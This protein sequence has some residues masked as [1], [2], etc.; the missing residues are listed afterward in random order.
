MDNYGESTDKYVPTDKAKGPGHGMVDNDLFFEYEQ[1]GRVI[2]AYQD[3]QGYTYTLHRDG[4]EVYRMKGKR[5][6]LHDALETDDPGRRG[7]SSTP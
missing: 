1:A 5:M 7:G 6:N 4:R 3:D 2:R